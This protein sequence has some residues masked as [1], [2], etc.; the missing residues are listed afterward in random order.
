[1]LRFGRKHPP[2]EL[3]IHLGE[4]IGKTIGMFDTHAAQITQ[5][6]LLY[7]KL[8]EHAS[9]EAQIM[10]SKVASTKGYLPICPRRKGRQ[11]PKKKQYSMEA[12]VKINNYSA[13]P[14]QRSGGQLA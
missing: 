6:A 14:K 10:L 11:S 7:K 8:N 13:E 9:H 3:F 1:M 2:S 4:A 5:I 12:I